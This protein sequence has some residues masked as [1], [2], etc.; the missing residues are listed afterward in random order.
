MTEVETYLV[1]I[2]L[3]AGFYLCILG[4]LLSSKRKWTGRIALMEGVMDRQTVSLYG[5]I[6]IANTQGSRQSK[7]DEFFKT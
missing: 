4:N 7:I 3:C 5:C 2:R 6:S 1:W